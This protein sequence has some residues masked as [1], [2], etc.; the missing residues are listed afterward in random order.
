MI[1]YLKRCSLFSLQQTKH[2]YINK[3]SFIF[4][5][6]LR[7]IQGRFFAIKTSLIPLIFYFVCEKNT[8]PPQNTLRG[9]CV[10]LY[11]DV[12]NLFRLDQALFKH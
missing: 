12:F 8:E 7:S 2:S 11:C 9:F 3:Y 6:F 5:A 1:F 10:A 4:F